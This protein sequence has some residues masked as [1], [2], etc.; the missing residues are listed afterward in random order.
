M[1]CG[2]QCIRPPRDSNNNIIAWIVEP[3]EQ[4]PNLTNKQ[5]KF[6]IGPFKN[7]TEFVEN[8]TQ[9]WISDGDKKV[10]GRVRPFEE[11]CDTVLKQV[12]EIWIESPK[13]RN[14]KE[15]GRLVH[16]ERLTSKMLKRGDLVILVAKTGKRNW[17]KCKGWLDQYTSTTHTIKRTSHETIEVIQGNMNMQ[18]KGTYLQ[19]SGTKENYTTQKTDHAFVWKNVWREV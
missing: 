6:Y 9:V 12:E 8:E 5:E 3:S 17:T 16:E 7:L 11:H 1:L 15:Q 19:S 2:H 13:V 4:G 14:D 18:T 10:L